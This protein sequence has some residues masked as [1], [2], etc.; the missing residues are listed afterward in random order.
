[1]EAECCDKNLIPAPAWKSSAK[2]Q[3]FISFS[4]Q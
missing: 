4:R 1:M 2:V 3:V